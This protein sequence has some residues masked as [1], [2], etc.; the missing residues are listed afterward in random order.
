MAKRETGL[1]PHVKSKRSHKTKKR[2][3]TKK[4][5]LQKKSSKCK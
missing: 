5:M 3:A 2:L 1:R 4:V